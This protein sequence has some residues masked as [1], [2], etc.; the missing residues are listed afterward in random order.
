MNSNKSSMSQF[1][2]FLAIFG[3]LH[4][5]ACGDAEPEPEPQQDEFTEEYGELD[6]AEF[7]QMMDEQAAEGKSDSLLAH[8]ICNLR[9]WNDDDICHHNC[10]RDP[11][12]T[13]PALGP[14]PEGAPTR[15]PIILAH[16]FMGSS[17][18]FW[19]FHNV[20]DALKADG[21]GDGVVVDTSVQPFNSFAVRAETLAAQVDQVLADTGAQKVHIVAHSMGG[22]D[23]RYMICMLG[24]GAYAQRVASLTTISTPHRGT[25]L[26]E[27]ALRFGAGSDAVSGIAKL[28]GRLLTSTELAADSDTGAA[29]ESL[30]PAYTAEFNELCPNAPQVRYQSYAGVSSAKGRPEDAEAALNVC[31][32]QFLRHP[33]SA[34]KL[35]LMLQVPAKFVASSDVPQ[36]G[37]A[38]VE[39]AKWGHFRGCIPADH[40]DQVGQIF[41]EDEER[42]LFG[43]GFDH[44][45]FYRNLAYDLVNLE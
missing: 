36:D 9:G 34:D 28:L 41:V 38:T 22:L 26:V 20:S 19:S 2:L 12:C 4:L 5:A 17:E 10:P 35:H 23:A 6:E 33:Q 30:T 16:G 24:E 18:N 44:I 45:R 11:V 14:E 32:Q 40:L 8:A 29:L 25:E 15:Y 1:G 13:M 7:D 42:P 3:A 21:H 31:N 39:S 43:T 37:M 27:T